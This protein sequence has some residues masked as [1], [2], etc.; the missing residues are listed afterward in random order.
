MK[1]RMTPMK[2]DAVV[3]AVPCQEDEVVD[4]D[5]RFGGEQLGDEVAFLPSGRLPYRSWQDRSSLAAL[6]RTFRP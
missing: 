2:G 5:R 1:S 6:P 4:G 3:E